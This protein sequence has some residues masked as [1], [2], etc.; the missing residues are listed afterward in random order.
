MPSIVVKIEWD[1]PDD[2]NWL[3]PY[4]LELVLAEYCTNTAFD[5]SEITDYDDLKRRNDRTYCAYCGHEVPLDAEDAEAKVHEHIS[6]C[7]YHPLNIKIQELEERLKASVEMAYEAA[8][9]A[10]REACAI[11]AENFEHTCS[12]HTETM[13][14]ERI[15][16]GRP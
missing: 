8:R 4:S 10:T 9:G 14:A 5:V 13:I 7:Q 15:R 1:V 12:C 6:T 2:P 11:I 3:N 16:A